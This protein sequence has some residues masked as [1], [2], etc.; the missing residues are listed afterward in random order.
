MIKRTLLGLV[1]V[2]LA[3]A[4]GLG[5]EGYLRYSAR[6]M[7]AAADA[8][9]AAPAEDLFRMAEA[10]A[11]PWVRSEKLLGAI[12]KHSD[13]DALGKLYLQLLSYAADENAGKTRELLF[14][15]RAEVEILLD[16]EK[17]AW[18]NVLKVEK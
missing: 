12:I 6:R 3:F 8:A 11:A 13:A 4:L 2:G 10:A 17:V 18:Y 7:T 15:C 9:L 5:G 1:C 14:K 16:G